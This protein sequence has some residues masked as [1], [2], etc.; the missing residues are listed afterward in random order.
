MIAFQFGNSADKPVQADYTGDGKA[1]VAF[2]RPSTGQW[3]VMRSENFSYYAVPFG[4]ATDIPTPG[5]YDGDGQV[6][7]AVFRPS[8]ATWFV[9]R[10]TGG[11]TI[12]AF[13]QT[14][15]APVPGAYVP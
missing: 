15:D 1:D 13:G 8:T 7:A 12:Q 11:T 4:L 3:F 14:G 5:D 10:S 9:R 6:D 2:F